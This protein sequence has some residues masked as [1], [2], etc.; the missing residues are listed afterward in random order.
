MIETSVAQ[1]ETLEERLVRAYL[2][3]ADERTREIR[4]YG[5]D[6]D[7]REE[8]EEEARELYM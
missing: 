3:A 8:V 6:A 7:E 5:L 4:G 2:A 1:S